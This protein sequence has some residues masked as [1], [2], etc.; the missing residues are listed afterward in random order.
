MGYEHFRH[1]IAAYRHRIGF[2]RRDCKPMGLI[3]VLEVVKKPGEERYWVDVHCLQYGRDY[4]VRFDDDEVGHI[5]VYPSG[6]LTLD[7][8]QEE[9]DQYRVHVDQARD[10]F[11]PGDDYVSALEDAY[12][13]FV[14]DLVRIMETNGIYSRFN[15]DLLMARHY[16]GQM[17]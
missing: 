16:L 6:Y 1:P 2:D 12:H 14:S 11:E 13:D 4:T 7:S 8:L 3:R 9:L 10:F 5:G 15:H 17:G